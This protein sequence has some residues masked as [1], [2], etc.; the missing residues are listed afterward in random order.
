MNRLLRPSKTNRW[1]G[2]CSPS[3]KQTGKD[4]VVA[5]EDGVMSIR[6]VRR[7]SDSSY[8]E[9]ETRFYTRLIPS[10]DEVKLEDVIKYTPG[11]SEL[12]QVMDPAFTKAL[13]G[14]RKKARA[15]L[16]QF[17]FL[18]KDPDAPA[19]CLLTPTGVHFVWA[20]RDT[21]DPSSYPTEEGAVLDFATLRKKKM[22]ND[23]GPLSSFLDGK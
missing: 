13:G 9:T 2:D 5:N 12:F 4:V 22:L 10:G 17:Y 14:D 8:T 7:E 16:K 23:S 15:M 11:G 19:D 21:S 1:S 20:R 6:S 18:T 3:R